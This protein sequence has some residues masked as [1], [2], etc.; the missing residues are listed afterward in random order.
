MQNAVAIDYTVSGANSNTNG[1]ANPNTIV[2]NGDTLTVGTDGSIEIVSGDS[3]VS[4]DGGGNNVAI[5]HGTITTVG[6][7]AFG[8]GVLNSA[9]SISFN[10]GFIGTLN[11]NAHGM[12]A[13]SSQ[14]VQLFNSGTIRTSGDTAYGIISY[15]SVIAHIENNGLIETDNV[16]SFGIFNDTSDNAVIRNLGEVNTKG[17][18]AYGIFNR[19]SAGVNILNA[20]SINT[21]ANR[22]TGIF[23]SNSSDVVINNTGAIDT[24]G[25][26]AHGIDNNSSSGTSIFNS[27]SIRTSDVGSIGIRSD[28]GLNIVNSGLVFAASVAE[29][30]IEIGTGSSEITL[31]AGSRLQGLVSLLGAS[32]QLT[33]DH[34]GQDIGWRFTFEDFDSASDILVVNGAPF[35]EENPGTTGAG[36]TTITVADMSREANAGAVLADIT[37]A[38]RGANLARISQA[39]T[40]AEA[41]GNDHETK[42]DKKLARHDWNFWAKGIG[43]EQDRGSSAFS[44]ATRHRIGGL[45]VGV[46]KTPSQN[47]L[48][49]AFGGFVQSHLQFEDLSL[50]GTGAHDIDTKATF[51]GV[52]GRIQTTH[53]LF[54]DGT[55][56]LGYADGDP[57]PR[58]RANNLVTGGVE[59]L[60]G[61]DASGFFAASSLTLGA[62]IPTGK[63]TA[64]LIPS[65]T[66]GQASQWRKGYSESGTAGQ[67]IEDYLAMVLNARLQLAGQLK[68]ATASG[69]F[70][71]ATIRGGLD[72]QKDVSQNVVL[73][74]LGKSF[75]VNSASDALRVGGFLGANISLAQSD[76]LAFTLDGELTFAGHNADE[77]GGTFNAGVV[78]RF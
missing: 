13:S 17:V 68:R 8:M 4:F 41:G 43:S 20:G 64:M 76:T 71:T 73:T 42:K 1:D 59:T 25:E 6:A 63:K 3:G 66:L 28:E 56:T 60:S 65:F 30:A 55:A 46:D 51:A 58:L 77:L 78:A 11:T 9:N 7:T 44:G 52:Y 15:S 74:M 47:T 70:L 23:N 31:R 36:S 2:G 69:V 49:G 14:E 39:W 16:T 19:M 37:G 67:S 34:N 27:G 72:A 5:N 61:G 33:L 24:G 35:V 50:N 75:S 57:G 54:A 26:D 10:N 12:V 62:H 32:D 53:G 21:S 18:E 48:F 22:A 38:V 29:N 40:I 45:V